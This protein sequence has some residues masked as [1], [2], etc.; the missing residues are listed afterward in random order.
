MSPSTPEATLPSALR[1]LSRFGPGAAA[2]G[3][4]LGVGL[5]GYANRVGLTRF[6]TRYEQLEILQA[7]RGP[8]RILHISDIHYVP[9]QQKKF[10]WLQSLAD[11]QP[12]LVVNTGDNLSHP[13]AVD[14]VL[15]ALGPLLRF[16][17]VFV[18]GSNDYYAPRLKNP[19]A[20]LV[21]PSRHSEDRP[22][23]PWRRLFA[24]F[25]ASG[26]VSLRNRHH[27]MTLGPHAVLMSGVDDPHIDRDS[28]AGWPRGV[29]SHRSLRLGVAHAPLSRVLSRFADTGADLILSGHTH[30][31][32]VC[33]PGGR[34]LTTNCDLP[35][36]QAKGLSTVTSATGRDVPL[37][38][39][40]GIGTS[41]TAPVRFNCPPEATVL[42]LFPQR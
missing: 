28:F 38:V 15:E 13:D 6:T 39:S 8:L 2:A 7:G 22:E 32:Q 5:A 36:A 29:A 9:G 20:Y 12:D 24:G 25:N 10:A 18:P 16:P 33:L 35:T 31:G 14:E 34:A 37:H 27:A 23:L 26:W 17:G 4:V 19:L 42:D 30:G 3:A 1:V 41:A 11:L 21:A 40:A